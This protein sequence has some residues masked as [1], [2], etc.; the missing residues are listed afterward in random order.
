MFFRAIPFCVILSWL[1]SGYMLRAVHRMDR[2]SYG[3][4][5]AAA[6]PPS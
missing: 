2:I 6:L 5:L 3:A 1:A 4:K